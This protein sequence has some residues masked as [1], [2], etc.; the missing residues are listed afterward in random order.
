MFR[1]T[2][3]VAVLAGALAIQTAFAAQAKSPRSHPL[4]S[5]EMRAA[6]NAFADAPAVTKPE[7][8]AVAAQARAFAASVQPWMTQYR[9]I[10]H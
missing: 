7:A 2:A 3:F 4:T 9:A 8:A 1:T 6:V 10:K 5:S